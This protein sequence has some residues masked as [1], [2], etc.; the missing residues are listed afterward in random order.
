MSTHNRNAD[1]S[2][3]IR[4]L[5]TSFPHRISLARSSRKILNSSRNRGALS[6]YKQRNKALGLSKVTQRIKAEARLDSKIHKLLFPLLFL[7]LFLV[8]L[9][10]IKIICCQNSFDFEPIKTLKESYIQSCVP[11]EYN[12]SA[13]G[14]WHE[15]SVYY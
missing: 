10:N 2:V 5:L 13:V 9:V 14:D 15:T 8:N 4:T 1:P 3:S 7:V 11:M 6:F 12:A